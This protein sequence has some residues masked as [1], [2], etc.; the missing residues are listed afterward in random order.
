MQSISSPLGRELW[1]GLLLLLTQN[2]IWSL[3]LR[4]RSRRWGFGEQSSTLGGVEGEKSADSSPKQ[5]ADFVVFSIKLLC[6]CIFYAENWPPDEWNCCSKIPRLLSFGGPTGGRVIFI[7]PQ[8]INESQQSF[9]FVN[10]L[11][12]LWL[13]NLG[14][15]LNF[16]IYFNFQASK[17]DFATVCHYL[18]DR[19]AGDFYPSFNN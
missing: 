10:F 16:N 12:S 6:H 15:W 2:E 13:F 11:G 5:W 19:S 8:W 18:C 7:F 14:S 9:L 17:S 4:R 1:A 3:G